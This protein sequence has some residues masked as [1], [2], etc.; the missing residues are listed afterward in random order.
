MEGEKPWG[1]EPQFFRITKMFLPS[2][3]MYQ[4]LILL[5]AYHVITSQCPGGG[6]GEASHSGHLSNF[7]WVVTT[8]ATRNHV[9][10]CLPNSGSWGGDAASYTQCSGSFSHVAATNDKEKPSGT[11][12]LV[13]AAWAL[14]R[15]W[16]YRARQKAYA[17]G[18]LPGNRLSCCFS[19]PSPT[20]HSA[21]R[22]RSCLG[23]DANCSKS[24]VRS[25]MIFRG[26]RFWSL[27][28]LV[29]NTCNACVKLRGA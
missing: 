19:L 7:S 20:E 24:G 10:P 15:K 25:K 5:Q 6:G 29:F 28:L 23:Y 3:E 26:K 9:P 18:M 14:L 11:Q 8:R 22:G 27:W 12:L 13:S 1:T 16:A 2:T 4:G 17:A 21:S